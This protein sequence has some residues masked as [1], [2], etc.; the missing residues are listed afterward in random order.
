MYEIYFH[1]ILTR[2]KYPSCL[3][4]R[5][6]AA[7]ASQLVFTMWYQKHFPFLWVT[8]P[9]ISLPHFSYKRLQIS[10]ADDSL[11]NYNSQP[12]SHHGS[13]PRLTAPRSQQ[14]PNAQAL[15]WGWGYLHE[16]QCH[17]LCEEGYYCAKSQAC[18]SM[19][20]ESDELCACVCVCLTFVVCLDNTDLISLD[21]LEVDLTTCFYDILSCAEAV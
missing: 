18:S 1:W 5:V 14:W 11:D 19:T 9:W 21:H 10:S 7:A 17:F 4:R 16:R 12:E 20:R 2:Q 13:L 8:N 3:Q 15:W 6:L